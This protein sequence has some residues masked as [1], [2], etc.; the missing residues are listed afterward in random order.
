MRT[1][2][3]M[4][5]IALTLTLVSALILSSCGTQNTPTVSSSD[6]QSS[7]VNS[8]S[9]LSFMSQIPTRFTQNDE[10]VSCMKQNT[11]M[12]MQE[13]SYMMDE[14]GQISCDEF[15]SEQ[16]R[17]A[18]KYTQVTSEAQNAWDVNICN[19]L[20]DQSRERCTLEVNMRLAMDTGDLSVC[21]SLEDFEKVDCNNRIISSKATRDLDVRVCD[22]I[23]KYEWDEENY[24]KTMCLE[25]VQFMLDSAREQARIDEENA[26]A[27]AAA[28]AQMQAESE[29]ESMFEDLDEDAWEEG[30]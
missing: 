22:A 9:E 29:Q 17:D 28:E 20:T 25:E 7:L 12:C 13:V 4:R 5:V 3:S 2:M 19:T 10:F 30:E 14:S 26:R 16:S 11:D 18:C 24:Q 6:T 21:E 27:L 23:L 15:I 8:R 1:L